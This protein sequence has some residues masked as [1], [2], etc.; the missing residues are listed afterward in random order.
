[1]AMYRCGNNGKPVSF[2]A[3]ESIS[4]TRDS[5]ELGIICESQSVFSMDVEVTYSL[6]ITYSG[7]GSA[8]H[9]MLYCGDEII[10]QED[11]FRNTG[12][13]TGTCILPAG[14]KISVHGYETGSGALTVKCEMFYNYKQ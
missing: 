8:G 12:T 9:A 6:S 10:W 7:S 3:H 2:T 14:K 4:G 5:T 13:I 1:M 11:G